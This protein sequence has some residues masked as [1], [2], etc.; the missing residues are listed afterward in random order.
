MQIV[1]VF[2]LVQTVVCVCGLSCVLNK[3]GAFCLFQ[4]ADS[5]GDES[6]SVFQV[7]GHGGCSPPHVPEHKASAEG[8]E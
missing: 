7:V 8:A 5:D 4:F 3:L 2:C 6:G 1:S